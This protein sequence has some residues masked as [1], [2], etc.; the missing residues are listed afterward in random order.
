MEKLWE[1]IIP[2]E[3]R[4]KAIAELEKEKEQEVLKPRNRKP[5]VSTQQGGKE[6]GNVRILSNSPFL[7][8]K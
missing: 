5:T 2:E 8:M 7:I 3:E 6:G 4:N 1:E